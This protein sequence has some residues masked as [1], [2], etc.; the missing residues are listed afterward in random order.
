MTAGR[1][2]DRRRPL[3]PGNGPLARVPPVLAFVAVLAVFL[4][5]VWLGGVPGAAMLVALAGGAGVLLAATWPR[6]SAPERTVRLLV[7][8]VVLGIALERLA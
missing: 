5:G 2:P 6:L 8:V 7:I 4:L 1:G 3:L